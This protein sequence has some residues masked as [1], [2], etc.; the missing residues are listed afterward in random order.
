[1]ETETTATEIGLTAGWSKERWLKF[2][3][4]GVSAGIEI[5]PKRAPIAWSGEV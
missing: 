1:M 4:T 3:A 2:S 5:E